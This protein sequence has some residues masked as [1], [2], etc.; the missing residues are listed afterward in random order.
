[1][2]SR[3]LP[4]EDYISRRNIL[5][6]DAMTRGSIAMHDKLQFANIRF[7]LAQRSVVWV[8]GRSYLDHDVPRFSR[9]WSM[10]QQRNNVGLM[11]VHHIWRWPNIKPTSPVLASG[12]SF[13]GEIMCDHVSCLHHISIHTDPFTIVSIT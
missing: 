8:G 3:T 11:V 5:H 7:M 4:A 10:T 12:L 13:V 2:F 1:M 6:S 9:S